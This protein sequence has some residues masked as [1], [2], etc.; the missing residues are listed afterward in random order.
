RLFSLQ[1]FSFYQTLSQL[2]SNRLSDMKK[3]MESEIKLKYLSTIQDIAANLLDSPDFT[4]IM[5]KHPSL[6]ELIN[7]TGNVFINE[8]TVVRKN[9]TPDNPTLY[10]L[11]EW[12][13]CGPSEDVFACDD[14][15][16][17]YGH[18]IGAYACGLLAARIPNH[19]K[20]WV[21]WLRPEMSK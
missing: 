7:S 20:S 19:N 10:A 2:C 18:D 17:R 5:G 8:K 4:S 14:L 16:S 9:S 1:E 12:L 13:E 21:L 15:P 11:I 6:D 3:L